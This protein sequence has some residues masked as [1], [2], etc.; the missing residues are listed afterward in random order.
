MASTT[1]PSCIRCPQRRPGTQY[2][3][4][5]IDSAPPATATSQSPSAI[6]CAADTIACSPVPHSRFSVKAGVSTGSPPFTDTTRPRYMS[7]TSVWITLPNTECPTWP[8]S[9]PARLTASRT[10][11]APRSQGGTAARPPPYLPIGVRVPDSTKTSRPL[12]ITPPAED[13]S[14]RVKD[15]R[16]HVHA[17]VDGPDLPGDIGGLV[18]RQEADHPGDLVGPA[19]P[20]QRDLLAYPVQSLLGH[21]GHHVGGDVAGGDR[22]DGQPDPVAHRLVVPAQLEDRLFGHRLRESEQAGLGGGVVDLA[23]VAGLADHR[24]DVDDPAGAALEHVLQRVLGHE[25][26]A[27]QVDRDH[28]QPVVVGHLGHGPVDGD[29]G[30]VDQDVQPAALVD[31]LTQDAA[32]II[33]VADV[34]LVHADLLSGVIGGHALVELLRAL[35][36]PPVARRH[37]RARPGQLAADGGAYPAGTP[38]DQGDPVADLAQIS[39]LRLAGLGRL[40]RC[41]HVLTSLL[42]HA[43]YELSCVAFCSRSST[44]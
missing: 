11:V 2:W 9:T 4:R 38:G 39:R 36:V 40:H 33:G 7:R 26:R 10:T 5:L 23:D 42:V 32:A 16:S 24:G 35:A 34:P 25:E 13:R 27:R 43:G 18:G 6:A 1:V 19:E 29:P 8:G 31:D 14:S 12:S 21:L 37:I 20:A 44:E 28:P 17:A 22:V 15:R 41:R 3:P 30:V